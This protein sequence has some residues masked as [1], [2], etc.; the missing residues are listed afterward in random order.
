MRSIGANAFRECTILK[1]VTFCNNSN[2]EII[3][4]G[5]FMNSGITEFIAPEFLNWLGHESFAQCS[6]LKIVKLNTNL[7]N[8]GY[9]DASLL[10]PGIF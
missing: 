2:L 1:K 5:A 6:Q 3:E 10:L 7:Q 9:G 4:R 8:L